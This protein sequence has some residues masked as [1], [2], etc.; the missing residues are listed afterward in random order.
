MRD[1]SVEGAGV[2]GRKEARW[3]GPFLEPGLHLLHRP[4]TVIHTYYCYMPDLFF[5]FIYTRRDHLCIR[6]VFHNQSRMTCR[7]VYRYP[8][9]GETFQ[10]YLT[11][12]AIDITHGCRYLSPLSLLLLERSH[13]L[14][15]HSHGS[16]KPGVLFFKNPHM[17]RI[18]I[19]EYPSHV[20]RLRVLEWLLVC[21]W[22]YQTFYGA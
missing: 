3:E 8:N 14:L 1:T 5:V 4:A 13:A 12:I 2:K 19:W 21:G 10:I 7:Y 15:P 18:K 17:V 16:L 11:K 6:R 9:H 20:M 22:C